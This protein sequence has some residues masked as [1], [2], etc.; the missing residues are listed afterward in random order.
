MRERKPARRTDNE[1]GE[2]SVP[3]GM[4]GQRRTEKQTIKKAAAQF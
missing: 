1:K 4:Y 2:D 3:R